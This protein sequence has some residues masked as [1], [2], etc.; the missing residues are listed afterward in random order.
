MM[1]MR[2]AMSY[3]APWVIV[4]A[5]AVGLSWL[6]VRDVVR[7]AISDSSAPEPSSG[8]V[9][10][11]SPTVP[12]SVG[13]PAA[14]DGTGGDSWASGTLSPSPTP[15]ERPSGDQDHGDRE[16]H[17]EVRSF[18]TRGGRAVLALSERRGV[19]LVSATPNP[20]FETR[21]SSN[22]GWL[23][24]DFRND[25]R[26]SSVIASWYDHDTVVKVYEYDGN[27]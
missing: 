9:I 1:A 19:R 25:D 16:R 21:V 18:S 12:G 5:L 4:T 24:V 7:G 6:G 11:A 17:G 27:S 26:T 22:E 3:V 20:G 23:R 14:R 10:H 15:S 2:G 8:P 13:T